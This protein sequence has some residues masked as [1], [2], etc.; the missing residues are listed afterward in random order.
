[1]LNNNGVDYL[2][3]NDE[4]AAIRTF[5][6]AL[7]I[8]EFISNDDSSEQLILP[9][10]NHAIGCPWV[11]IP[12][13]QDSAFFIYNRAILFEPP[14]SSSREVDLLFA[15]AAIMFNLALTYHHYGQ[16]CHQVP[17]LRRAG[18]MYGRVIQLVAYIAHSANNPTSITSALAVVAMN[19]QAQI[20]HCDLVCEY[21]NCRALL[22]RV[23]VLSERITS[24]LPEGPQATSS[25]SAELF[26]KRQFDEIYL[27]VA[28]VRAPT[29]APSA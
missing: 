27:N 9:E 20:L 18:F 21:S 23:R 10:A 29:A 25:V 4:C 28:L 14:S 12:A 11:E 7:S 13:L 22:E 1:M 15:N 2:F 19:N 16:K 24:L 6:Q 17:L 8:M 3:A 26:D 5:K